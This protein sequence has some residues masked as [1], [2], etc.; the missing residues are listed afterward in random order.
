MQRMDHE[1]T[2]TRPLRQ[3]PFFE[4]RRIP[5]DHTFTKFSGV[6]VNS[7]PEQF[8]ITDVLWKHF[9][10]HIRGIASRKGVDYLDKKVKKERANA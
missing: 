7:A 1:F 3:H 2:V 10:Y 8:N 5:Q 4:L 6:E 9:E